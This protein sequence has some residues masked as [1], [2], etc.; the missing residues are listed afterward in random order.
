MAALRQQPGICIRPRQLRLPAR[1]QLRKISLHFRALSHQRRDLLRDVLAAGRLAGLRLRRLRG[2]V[3]RQ[4]RAV[5]LD[6]AIKRRQPFGKLLVRRDARLAGVAMQ[7][8]AVDR[9]HLAAHQA[10]FAHHKHEIPVQGLERRPVVLA[11][12]SDGAIARRKPLHQPDQLKIAAS[13]AFKTAR[14]ADSVEIAVKI[15]LRQVGRIIGRL[16]YPTVRPRAAKPKLLKIERRHVGIDRANRIVPP[17][18]IFNP[19]RK[20]AWLLPA[21]TGLEGVIRHKTNRT[22][23]RQMSYEFLPR[24]SC[25]TQQLRRRRLGCGTDN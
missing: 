25:E 13:L 20:K 5:S 21:R 19:R 14:G 18:I 23:I 10:E 9:H 12:I 2:V 3:F 1:L 6:V 17:H 15:K 11:E 24:L 16:A 22:L 8:R 4:R 7:K